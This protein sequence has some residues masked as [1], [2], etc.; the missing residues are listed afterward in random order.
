MN[1]G[2]GVTSGVTGVVQTGV[3]AVGTV[4]NGVVKGVGTVGGAAVGG[5]GAVA[6]GARNVVG[7]MPGM[8]AIKNDGKSSARGECD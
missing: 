3:G 8:G 1:V 2:K 4:G 7:A 6:G 5:V